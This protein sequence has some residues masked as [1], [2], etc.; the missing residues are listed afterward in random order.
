MAHLIPFGL[1]DEPAAQGTSPQ[2]T[3]QHDLPS[4]AVEM[5][6]L[7]SHLRT[8]VVSEDD[9][10][11]FDP[12]QAIPKSLRIARRVALELFSVPAGE[13]P[14][15]RIFSIAGRLLAPERSRLTPEHL[16]ESTFVL[17]NSSAL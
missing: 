12:L 15:E 16:M 1:V 14:S 8:V 17:K 10:D 6:N 11:R 9:F 13:A 4:T 2:P 7:F 3:T 5:K